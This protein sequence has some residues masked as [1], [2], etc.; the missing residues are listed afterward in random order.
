M[1]DPGR[2]SRT[3]IHYF[4]AEGRLEIW[5]R[6]YETSGKELE[7]LVRDITNNY[8]HAGKQVNRIVINGH[9]VHQPGQSQYDQ[10]EKQHAS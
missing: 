3:H 7:R 9:A 5:V 10:Q 2:W 4:S 8:R 1:P 6:D